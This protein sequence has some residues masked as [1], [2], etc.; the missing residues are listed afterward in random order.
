MAFDAFLSIDGISGES[1]DDKHKG[2]IEVLYYSHGSS[3]PAS[4]TASSAGGGSTERVTHHP[5]VIRK[6]IDKASPL[7][8]QACCSGKHFATVTLH[9]NRAGG[10]KLQYYE[11]KME[12]VV[13]SSI[14]VAEGGAGGGK[15]STDD[16]TGKAM[17]AT[18]PS[19]SSSSRSTV[20]N[21]GG[22][23][24]NVGA[25]PV[26]TVTFDFGKIKWTYTQQKRADGTGGGNVA[27]GWDLTANKV[28]S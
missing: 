4:A 22:L 26:E 5:F 28:Y 15:T 17:T 27:G 20:G 21:V 23:G 3:Q 8:M 7:L 1:S 13:I 18:A 14:T 12:Q 11:V 24:S 16:W 25:L 19:S 10:D 9:L 2:W 6:E